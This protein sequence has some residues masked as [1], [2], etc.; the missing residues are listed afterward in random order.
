MGN[1]SILEEKFDLLTQS[2]EGEDYGKFKD[3]YDYIRWDTLCFYLSL[4]KKGK[5]KFREFKQKI[6]RQRTRRCLC[7]CFIL[8]MLCAI[9]MCT[10]FVVVMGDRLYDPQRFYLEDVGIP[11]S[12][13]H[14][15][16][17][18]QKTI[19][20]KRDII[21]NSDVLGLMKMIWPSFKKWHDVLT[22]GTIC[23]ENKD[24]YYGNYDISQSLDFCSGE[25]SRFQDTL[26]FLSRE[27]R[28]KEIEKIEFKIASLK[29]CYL[30]T[31]E[32]KYFKALEGCASANPEYFAI[33]YP[34]MEEWKRRVVV[35]EKA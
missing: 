15:P 9:V 14:E 29:T 33:N 7:R 34:F 24:R 19:L 22:M 35:E 27:N 5:K 28:D 13:D 17:S 11:T 8:I 30:F 31:R 1:Y 6:E 25:N 3:S 10:I 16:L 21:S 18:R 2:I 32:P 4:N 12:L 26:Q 20:L 23:A